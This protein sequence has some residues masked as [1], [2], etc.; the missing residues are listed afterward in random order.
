MTKNSF[1]AEV[2]FKLSVNSF[3]NVLKLLENSYQTVHKIIREFISSC[4]QNYSKTH[5]KKQHNVKSLTR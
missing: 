1:L 4:T 2:T 5:P 3:Q